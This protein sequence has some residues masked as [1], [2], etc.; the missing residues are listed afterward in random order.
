MRPGRPAFV[1]HRRNFGGQ[2]KVRPYV[3]NAGQWLPGFGHLGELRLRPVELFQC[4]LH[5]GGG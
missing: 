2:A 1:P 4:F 5:G 3:E